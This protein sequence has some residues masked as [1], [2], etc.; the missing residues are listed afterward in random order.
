MFGC[1][2]GAYLTVVV[3]L[4]GNTD[5]QLTTTFFS[6][7]PLTS[8]F[9]CA[10]TIGLVALQCVLVA[11]FYGMRDTGGGPEAVGG[12]V[13]RSLGVNLVLMHFV[14]SLAALVFYGGSLGVPIGD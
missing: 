8:I 10:I 3:I 4:Q 11:C 1:F 14:F 6:I 7:F 2:C 5:T 12:A 9:F 13:A